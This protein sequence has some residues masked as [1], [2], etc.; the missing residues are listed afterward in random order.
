MIHLAAEEV[1][2]RT[3]SMIAIRFGQQNRIEIQHRKRNRIEMVM[4]HSMLINRNNIIIIEVEQF[5]ECTKFIIH[6]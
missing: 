2:H 6:M 3:V 1:V 5:R 4:N